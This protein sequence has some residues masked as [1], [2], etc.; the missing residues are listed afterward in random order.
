[1][2]ETAVDEALIQA[3]RLIEHGDREAIRRTITGLS[4]LLLRGPNVDQ[5]GAV[6]VDD[7]VLEAGL[8]IQMRKLRESSRLGL[9]IAEQI[10]AS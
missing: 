9:V 4:A 3:E 8:K 5:G 10:S 2:N 1:M 7:D 6:G